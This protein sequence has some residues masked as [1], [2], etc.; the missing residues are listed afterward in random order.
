MPLDSKFI[1][2]V[3]HIILCQKRKTSNCQSLFTRE[4]HIAPICLPSPCANF[5]AGALCVAGGYGKDAFGD[6]GRWLF[7][8][9][10][11]PF[12]GLIWFCLVPNT[13]TN[14]NKNAHT[15]TN[16]HTIL[17]TNTRYADIQKEVVV[18]LVDPKTCQKKLRETRLG[19]VWKLP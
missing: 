14:E 7:F 1:K 19:K 3:V 13:N 17:I 10:L 15:N 12:Y 4:K 11:L 16:T 6:K 9:S 5:E 18:P 8:S 2:Y